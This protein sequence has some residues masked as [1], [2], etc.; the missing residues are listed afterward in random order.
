MRSSLILAGRVDCCLGSSL[1]A[2]FLYVLCRCRVIYDVGR[3]PYLHQCHAQKGMIQIA[4]HVPA[5]HLAK[6]PS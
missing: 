6:L 1:C 3:L 4:E 5:D 2:V